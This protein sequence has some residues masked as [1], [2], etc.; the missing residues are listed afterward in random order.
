[1]LSTLPITFAASTYRR[2]LSLDIKG[3]VPN[4]VFA[5]PLVGTKMMTLGPTYTA[6][7]AMTR[8]ASCVQSSCGREANPNGYA[9]SATR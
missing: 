5:T 1:M 7:D 3:Y 2:K 8:F 4:A 6:T 9:M